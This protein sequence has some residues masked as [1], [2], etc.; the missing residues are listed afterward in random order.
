MHT[1]QIEI[2]F[3]LRGY[4]H[5]NCFAGRIMVCFVQVCFHLGVASIPKLPRETLF[6][7]FFV[8]PTHPVKKQCTVADT[9]R[10]GKTI[11]SLATNINRLLQL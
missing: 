11:K 10:L 7:R 5:E 8:R 3:W 1:K 4:L 2:T 9:C 6:R